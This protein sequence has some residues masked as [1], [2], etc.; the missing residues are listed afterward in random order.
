MKL[1]VEK[2]LL[3]GTKLGRVESILRAI[4]ISS[5]LVLL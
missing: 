1:M 5:I 3:K 4:A 2:D